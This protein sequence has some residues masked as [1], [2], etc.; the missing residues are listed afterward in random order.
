MPPYAIFDAIFCTARSENSFFLYD[1]DCRSV[2]IDIIYNRETKVPFQF[3]VQMYQEPKY[4]FNSQYKCNRAYYV[5]DVLW[6][7]P[8]KR[9]QVASNS[10]LREINGTTFFSLKLFP[11]IP[12]G[13]K[14]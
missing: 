4:P 9:I 8:I 14:N 6:G 5:L 2:F 10:E 7:Q 3:A 1:A 11:L 13:L 12:L